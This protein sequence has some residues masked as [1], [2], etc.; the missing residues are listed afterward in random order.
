MTALLN[1]EALGKRF[2]GLRALRSVDLEIGA[3]ELV[4]LIGPNGSGK[5]TLL[6]IVGGYDVPTSGRVRL[7]G[8]RVDGAAPSRLA[9][10]GVGRSF[11]VAKPF[12]RLSVLENVLAPALTDWSRSRR[13]AERRGRDALAALGL[14]RLA[15]ARADALSGG[16]AKL[17]EFARITMLRPRLV[18]L[19][20]PFGGVHPDLKRVMY[21]RIRDWHAEGVAVV[22]ISHDMGSVFELC[23]RVVTLSFG[24][25]I[26]DGT[27]E[28]VRRDEAV[29]EAYLGGH[30]AA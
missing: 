12:R 17:L 16:Q 20:E 18:L 21:G 10:L 9:R 25:I 4:G 24:E 27:P 1:V 22:L 30:D 8:R 11:Q 7:D 5:T 6:N 28:A 23:R 2:G 15:D 14:E 3:G 26:A 19:D 29:I 13:E